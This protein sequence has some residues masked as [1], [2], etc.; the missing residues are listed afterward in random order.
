MWIL[1]NVGRC[2]LTVNRER[3][4]NT[5]SSGFDLPSVVW[6]DTVSVNTICVEQITPNPGPISR[7]IRKGENVY[8][9]VSFMAIKEDQFVNSVSCQCLWAGKD[10]MGRPSSTIWPLASIEP[11]QV[12]VLGRRCHSIV[13]KSMCI[14]CVSREKST[15]LAETDNGLT[16]MSKCQRTSILV[17]K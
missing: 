15:S 11:V 13:N 10:N 3:V 9:W 14:H 1:L 8:D 5:S 7:Q 4:F 6:C 2:E 17:C 16:F 12:Q